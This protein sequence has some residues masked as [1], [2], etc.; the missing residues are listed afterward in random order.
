MT[1]SI[2]GLRGAVFLYV[3]ALAQ[4]SLAGNCGDDVDGQRVACACGDVVISSVQLRASD[5]IATET[6]LSDGLLVRTVA[7]SGTV[8]V[9]LNGQTITGSGRGVGVRVLAGMGKGVILTGGSGRFATLTGFGMGVRSAAREAL[10]SVTRLHLEDN[11]MDGLSIRGHGVEI[12]NVTAIGNG[13][14]GVSISGRAPVLTGVVVNNNGRDGVH[15]TAKGA[16][17][18]ASGTDNGGQAIRVQSL[19]DLRNVEAGR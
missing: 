19:R 13:R 1:R 17:V 4:I 15:V 2:D 5:P 6:C 8:V 7:E 12:I 11:S 9:D 10:A 16:D 14:Y 3:L 18:E